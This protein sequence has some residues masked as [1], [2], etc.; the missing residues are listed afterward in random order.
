MANRYGWGDN[1]PKILPGT[2]GGDRTNFF[3]IKIKALFTDLFAKLNVDANKLDGI[4]AGAEKNKNAFA[5]IKVGSLLILANNQEDTF[6][7]V[8]GSNVIVTP[9]AINDKVTIGLPPSLDINVTGSAAKC[10]GCGEI[11]PTELTNSNEGSLRM[12]GFYQTSQGV[13][14]GSSAG[15]SYASIIQAS[16]NNSRINR[17][18]LRGDTSKP[19]VYHQ[20][21]N[22]NTWGPLTRFVMEGDNIT[23]NAASA[24]KL[25]TSRRINGVLFNGTGDITITAAANGGTSAACSGNAASATKATQDSRGQQ[26][27]STYIK[28]LSVSGRTVTYT[29]G[30]GTTGSFQTQDT[31]TTYTLASLGGAPKPQTAAGVGQWIDFRTLTDGNLPSGGTWAYFCNGQKTSTVTPIGVAAGGTKVAF[32]WTF[33]FGWRIA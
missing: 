26:I 12:S 27:D 33:G 13:A 20:A 24:T 4:Q 3:G 31:N 22:E 25:Q 10:N 15:M 7:I 21:Y 9:D 32:Q 19:L 18:I 30:N 1:E 28:G 16:R 14:N 6:E 17:I 2:Q 29:R 23:G 5:K 8:P 11:M